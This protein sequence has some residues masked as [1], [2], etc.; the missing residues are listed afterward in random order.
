MWVQERKELLEGK[1]GYQGNKNR[2]K[3]KETRRG[4][5]Q[6]RKTEG[7]REETDEGRGRKKQA[8][9]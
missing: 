5:K 2:R 8:R 4:E 7:R 3:V 1:S 6:A 9:V